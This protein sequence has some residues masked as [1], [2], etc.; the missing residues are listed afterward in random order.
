MNFSCYNLIMKEN[1]GTKIKELREEKGLSQMEL[2][3]Q[4]DIPQ[5]TLARYELEKSE[6]RITEIRKIC[7]YF[8]VSA[9]YLLGLE[10]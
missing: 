7:K 5:A 10:D 3:K 6:P 9:D 2:A 1:F 4:I 8:D